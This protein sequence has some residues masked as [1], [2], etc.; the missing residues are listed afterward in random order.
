MK[1]AVYVRQSEERGDISV[2]PEVQRDATENYIKSQGWE[3]TN[4]FVDIGKTGRSLSRPGLNALRRVVSENSI[5]KVCVYRLDRFSRRVRDFLSLSEEFEKNGVGI[6][7]VTENVDTQTAMGR[8]FRT[9]LVS[10]AEYESDVISL[11]VTDAM[12]KLAKKQRWTGGWVSFGFE[13]DREH[14]RLKPNKDAEI[15]KEI[16]NRALNYQGARKIADWLNAQGI[17]TTGGKLWNHQQILRMLK[18]VH[19]IADPARENRS[20]QRHGGEVLPSDHIGIID[21]QVWERTQTVIKGRTAATR[22]YDDDRFLLSGLVVAKPCGSS[23]AGQYRK[24]RDTARYRCQFHTRSHDHCDTCIRKSIKRE[25][26]E[27]AV[28][29]F[30]RSH[31]INATAISKHV[32]HRKSRLVEQ[33]EILESKIDDLSVKQDNLL[34]LFNSKDRHLIK[35]KVLELEESKREL[36]QRLDATGVQLRKAEAEI[37]NHEVVADKVTSIRNAN[38]DRVTMKRILSILIDR[39][40]I[41]V[42]TGEI[43]V[44]PI[45]H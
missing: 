5:D 25:P 15:V 32:Q 4:T 41:D 16:Y 28:L 29:E 1:T 18:S 19:Y 12:N 11:R 13:L 21:R 3:L 24:D 10:F 27:E 33:Y 2:S 35:K 14:K 34:D 37:Y 6:V 40:E 30:F 7:S 39:V 26:L 43:T 8:L 31:D 20:F 36:S 17:K 42:R 44:F 22:V 38:F 23:W 45:L 9:M